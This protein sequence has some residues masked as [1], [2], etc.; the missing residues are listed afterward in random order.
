[1]K[2]G[3]RDVY[4]LFGEEQTDFTMEPKGIVIVM[5]NGQFKVFSIQADHNRF[6]ALL[7]RFTWTELEEGVDFRNGEYRLE[8]KTA[9]IVEQGWTRA[10]SIPEILQFLQRQNYRQLFFL[11]KQ[12]QIMLQ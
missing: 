8:R 10:G 4:L 7:H 9:E 1:M 11:E 2:D 3:I 12:I 5:S 6:R